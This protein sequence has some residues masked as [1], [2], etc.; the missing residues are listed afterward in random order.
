MSNAATSPHTLPLAPSAMTHAQ[1]DAARVE[2]GE[3]FVAAL[4][5]GAEYEA[6]RAV[7]SARLAEL[8]GRAPRG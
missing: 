4:R 8:D 3:A 6:A 5:G 7:W 1:R 2:A